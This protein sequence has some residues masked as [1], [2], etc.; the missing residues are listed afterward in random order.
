MAVEL[1][2][3]HGYFYDLYRGKLVKAYGN[4]IGSSVEFFVDLYE[5]LSTPIYCKD[6]EGIYIYCNEAFATFM[7]M[8]REE[9]IGKS[10]YDIV[11]FTDP[12]M[13]HRK[14]VEV[15]NTKGIIQ[16]ESA[17]VVND[18]LRYFI[19]NKAP[20][21]NSEGEVVGIVGVMSDIT[22]NRIVQ[23]KLTRMNAMKE[24]MLR[25]SGLFLREKNQSQVTGAILNLYGDTNSGVRYGYYAKVNGPHLI[26]KNRLPGVTHEAFESLIDYEDSVYHRWVLSG[27]SSPMIVKHGTSDEGLHH[28]KEKNDILISLMIPIVVDD[29]LAGIFCFDAYDYD[30]FDDLDM[31]FA[32]YVKNHV[33]TYIINNRMYHEILNISRYDKLTNIF[34]RR[35]FEEHFDAILNRAKRYRE[36]FSLVI[37]DLN[38]LKATNDKY[39]H[40]AG[41]HIIKGFVDTISGSIRTSDIFA[42]FGGDEFIGIFFDTELTPLIEKLE[43]M[44][45]DLKHNPVDY[46]GNHLFCS[47]SFGVA[48]YPEDGESYEELFNAADAR[49]YE[50]KNG[51]TKPG[52]DFGDR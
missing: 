21:V 29:V 27:S 10:L 19:F 20:F 51:V 14:D 52:Y 9:L 30:A 7:G 36:R 22:E 31:E 43:S 18:E 40:L 1:E 35:Y 8:P 6:L 45:H 25:M 26:M 46:R 49:M 23:K 11:D 34:N 44:N 48:T 28:F 15:L 38:G 17:F 32:T 41:D 2:I 13:H 3:S 42:R 12:M 50:H 5:S 37:F 4:G 33:E 47:F 16:Y 24:A 39:G